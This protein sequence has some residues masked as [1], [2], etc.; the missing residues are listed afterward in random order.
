MTGAADPR[1]WTLAAVCLGVFILLLD[2]TIVN[3]A[4]VDIQRELGATLARALIDNGREA[5]AL[6]VL[7][8]TGGPTLEPA[9]AERRALLRA[10]ALL[11]GGDTVRALDA[12]RGLTGRELRKLFS[13]IKSDDDYT[14][15]SV[16]R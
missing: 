13:W 4:L 11:G 8:G 6:D 9:L 5:E 3:V 12:L 7:A 16:A 2:I 10:D 15:G 14:E 1:W